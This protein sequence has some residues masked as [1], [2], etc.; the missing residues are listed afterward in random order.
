MRQDKKKRSKKATKI[1]CA[2]SPFLCLSFFLP[3]FHTTCLSSILAWHIYNYTQSK[4]L[5]QC[6]RA[7]GHCSKKMCWQNSRLQVLEQGTDILQTISTCNQFI[8]HI[9]MRVTNAHNQL[10][11]RTME[12]R[13]THTHTHASRQCWIS[14]NT[15]VTT[16]TSH[17]PK[18]ISCPVRS[19]GSYW[20]C[21]YGNKEGQSTRERNNGRRPATCSLQSR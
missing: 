20:F 7:A 2:L 10:H 8:T 1:S 18:P 17:F 19:L 3:S 4:S 16:T 11:T 14:S 5:S 9:L 12:Y 15:S 13:H 21:H 6:T